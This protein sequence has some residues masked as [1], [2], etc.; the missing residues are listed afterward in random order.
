MKTQAIATC[1]FVISVASVGWV[2]ACNRSP[3]ESST[4]RVDKLFAEWNRS[5]SPGCSVG[6]SQ[7]GF[8]VYEHGY[9]MA[10]LELGVPITPAS[11]FHVASIS[12]QF[13][14]MSISLL[15]ARGQLSLDDDVS[16]Y[17]PEWANREHRVTIRDL[18]A[19][20]SGVRDGFT[21]LELA[22]PRGG[23]GD[24]NG[25]L[26]NLLARQRGLNFAPRSEYQYSNGGYVLLANLVKRVTGQSLRAFAE[27][28]IF[29]PLGMA[30]THV[31]DDPTMI[32]PNRA[33]GY[34][35]DKAGLHVAPHADFGR[36]VGTTGLMTTTGD[37]L[38]WEQ[39]FADVRVGSSALLTM[40]QT[41][42]V[43]SNGDVSPY[44]FGLEIGDDHGLRTVGHGGGDP[45]FGAYVIRYPD[46][47]LAVAVL[48]NLDN[49]G[50]S[51]G[52]LARSVAALYLPEIPSRPS[53]SA[54]TAPPSP[55][56][57]SGEQLASRVGLYRDVSKV[58]FGRIFLRDGKLVASPNAG[59][60]GDT[61]EMTPVSPNQF[62]IPGI[63][64]GLEFMPAVAGRPQE[65]RLTG[66]GPKP[67]LMQRVTEQSAP[68]STDLRAFA[69][70]YTCPDL[71]VTYAIS[72]RD[73]GLVMQLAGR[74]EIVLAPVVSDTFHGALIDIVRFSRDA[75]GVV[76]EFSIHTS[77]VRHLG[78]HRMRR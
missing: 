32:V 70:E 65:I 61:F 5:D 6:V 11:V 51:V 29:K 42:T 56:S 74:P 64:V 34:H 2:A 13:T 15:A 54:L 31:H 49:I 25:V 59:T 73:S 40:M 28:N 46:R 77:G 57:L 12:K 18:L 67:A 39:N 4:A 37:L 78:C 8:P 47:A 53:E 22:A 33:A 27:A 24:T 10:N 16:K 72:V 50:Q 43:L 58:T 38:Q 62:V 1:V 55:V 35:R 69:G 21:L 71:E 20:T 45:G 26:V 7:N 30:H 41:P 44:G 17:I 63:G 9:G 14:A 48:C 23:V 75:G 36:I 19:H 60:D 76:T 68:S 3:V 66:D 52:A